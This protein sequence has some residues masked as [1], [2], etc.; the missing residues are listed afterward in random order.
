MNAKQMKMVRNIIM[1]ATVVIGFICWLFIP[2]EFKNST[3]FH[4]GNGEYGSKI[5][6][7]ILLFLPLFALIP[8]KEGKEV[9][10]EDSAERE[11]LINEHE[12]NDAKRQVMIAILLGVT[13]IGILGIAALIL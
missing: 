6:A 10:T 8:D 7:L 5:W 9:H 11:K 3:F 4:I 1:A 2:N 12:L 13:V